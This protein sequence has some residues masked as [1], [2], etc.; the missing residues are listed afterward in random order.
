MS[1]AKLSISESMFAI[2]T[3]V[4]THDSAI[5]KHNDRDDEHGYIE[6]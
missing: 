6:K 3:A 4:V 2:K 5:Y 1:K